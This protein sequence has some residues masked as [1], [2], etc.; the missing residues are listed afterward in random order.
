MVGMLLCALVAAPA[1][2]Q[3]T[4]LSSTLEEKQVVPG[5]QYTGV[6]RVRNDSNRPHEVKLYQTDYA[7]SADGKTLYDAP[8]LAK[9]SNAKWIQ[10]TPQRLVI[11]PR[12]DAVARY[13]VTVPTGDLKGS[14]WSMIMVE[15]ISE[16]SLESSQTAPGNARAQVGLQTAV[17]YGVQIASH[18]AGEA[19]RDARFTNAS[20]SKTKSGKAALRF[21]FINTGELAYRPQFTIQLI[22]ANGKQVLERKASRGLVY[23]GSSIRQQFDL[24]ANVRGAHRLVVLAD[25]GGND[26]VGAQFSVSF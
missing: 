14:Y 13:T 21:D 24:P 9:R 16:G 18:F 7:F 5:E 12:G 25:T 3:V 11:P 2:A 19:T 20:A 6:I 17:R 8:G 10:I 26:L 23:P 22:D 4:L 15:P 1:D